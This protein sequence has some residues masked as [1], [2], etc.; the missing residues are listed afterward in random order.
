MGGGDCAAALRRIDNTGRKDSVARSFVSRRMT[1]QQQPDVEFVSRA[2]RVSST[3]FAA[4]EALRKRAH[5]SVCGVER[6]CE[7]KV[8]GAALDAALRLRRKT[9]RIMLRAALASHRPFRRRRV[10]LKPVLL[11]GIAAGGIAGKQKRRSL[12]FC[13]PYRNDGKRKRRAPLDADF[14]WAP[15][16]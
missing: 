14:C 10:D 13:A 1:F 7:R 4:C 8:M 11:S 12:F 6:F 2:M 16:P 15:L 5:G 9:K 3:S